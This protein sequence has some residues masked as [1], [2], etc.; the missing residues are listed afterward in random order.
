MST[1]Y[2]QILEYLEYPNGYS[3]RHAGAI[4]LLPKTEDSILKEIS[5]L[6]ILAGLTSCATVME[7]LRR[8]AH[9]KL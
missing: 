7:Q 2:A 1:D 4:S 8:L 3:S 6:G 5:R 9:P